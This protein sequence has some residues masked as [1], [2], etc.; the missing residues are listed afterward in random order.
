MHYLF[1]DIRHFCQQNFVKI[2]DKGISASIQ[3]EQFY[4]TSLQRSMDKATSVP[5]EHRPYESKS[6]TKKA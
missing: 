3:E 1:T 2:Y 6:A 4:I 5:L